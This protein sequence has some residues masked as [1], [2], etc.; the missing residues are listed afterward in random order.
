MTAQSGNIITIYSTTWCL[1]CKRAKQFLRD[2]RIPYINV[3]IE[4]DPAAMAYVEKVNKGMRSI[5]TI[6][7][8][9][10]DIL[11]EPSNAQLAEKVGLKT[12]AKR[13]FYDVVVIG[14]GPAGLTA[15]LYM[16]R[17]GIETLVIEKAGMG[18]PHP[19]LPAR[20]PLA[21]SRSLPRILPRGQRRWV[22]RVTPDRL[23]GVGGDVIGLVYIYLSGSCCCVRS[24]G[25]I[26]AKCRSRWINVS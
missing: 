18:G 1:D 11:V 4:Q 9:D 15:A 13:N 25:G 6:V 2:Q 14:G 5:P 22:G 10:G 23:D 26:A 3:D 12:E 24:W 19:S 8:P 21:R 20:L 17:E 7:F 16:A